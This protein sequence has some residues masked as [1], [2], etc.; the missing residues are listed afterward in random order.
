MRKITAD[1]IYTISGKPIEKGVVVLDENGKITAINTRAEHDA[2]TL[3]KY[4]GVIV[5]GFVNTHCHL[6]LS[7]MKGKVN[8]GTG[9]IPFISSVVQFRDFPEEVILSEIERADQEMWENGIVAVGDISNKLDTRATKEKS[10]IRY[11]TFVEMFDF[12]HDSNAATTFEQYKAVYDGQSSSNKN[13][14]SCVPHA[15]YSVS[16]ELFRLINE[17]NGNENVTVSIHNQETPHETALFQNKTGDFTDF[18]KMVGVPLIDWLPTHKSSIYYAMEQMNPNVRNL[19]VHNTM[20]S[21]ADIEAAHNWSEKVYWATCA[22]A[23]L[24]I[25]NRLPNYQDFL[26]TNA[27]MTIGTDS[28][29]SNWQLSILDEMK[30]IA[31]YQSYLSF[32]TLLTWATLNGAKALGYEEDLGSIEVGKSPGLNL[33]S[34]DGI[35][36]VTQVKRLV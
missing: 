14:K 24:Y 26:D 31:K 9:L 10:N 29:T 17:R 16:K 15:P 3:E 34:E 27:K 33:L 18:Y 22:N 25:E 21:K 4:E 5:P 19:F 28:L 7:H 2:A 12:M 35:S 11:Y 6:E 1:K 23:N 32:E 13:Q 30:T 36:A 20:T 8:T